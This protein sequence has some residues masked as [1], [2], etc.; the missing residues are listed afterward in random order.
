MKRVKHIYLLL[1]LEPE[2]KKHYGRK[3]IKFEEEARSVKDVF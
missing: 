2:Y 1:H 3:R